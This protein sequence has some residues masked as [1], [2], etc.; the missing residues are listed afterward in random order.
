MLNNGVG[1]DRDGGRAVLVFLCDTHESPAHVRAELPARSRDESLVRPKL[2]GCVFLA[3][4]SRVVEKVD[5]GKG[6]GSSS[7][8]GRTCL[9]GGRREVSVDRPRPLSEVLACSARLSCNMSCLRYGS[10]CA[11]IDPPEY[12]TRSTTLSSTKLFD[13]LP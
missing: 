12:R 10:F 8:N 6:I 3:R 13:A 1:L 9:S 7:L 4:S 5:P 11:S 2:L